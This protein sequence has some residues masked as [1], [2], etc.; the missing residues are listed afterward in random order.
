MIAWIRYWRFTTPRIAKLVAKAV[1]DAELPLAAYL[2]PEAK[3][4]R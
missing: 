2:L 4:L 3:L 1:T